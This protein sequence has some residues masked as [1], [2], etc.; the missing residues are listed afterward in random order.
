MYIQPKNKLWNNCYLTLHVLHSCVLSLI[1]FY[2]IHLHLCFICFVSSVLRVNQ[3]SKNRR[4]FVV[5]TFVVVNG[6]FPLKVWRFPWNTAGTAQQN[7]EAARWVREGRCSRYGSA[8]YAHFA[9]KHFYLL[10][11]LFWPS[12]STEEVHRSLQFSTFSLSLVRCW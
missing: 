5:G 8:I 10:P 6:A 7:N 1:C 4:R 2:Q 9:L 3:L 12:F 11:I